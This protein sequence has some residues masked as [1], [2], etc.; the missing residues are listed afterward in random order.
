MA[1]R[2]ARLLLWGLWGA[3]LGGA[4]ALGYLVYAYTR[5]LPD[6]SAFERLRLSAPP[7][8]YARGGPTLALLA[9][10]E[11]GRAIHRSLVRLS[12]VSPAALAAIVFSE[13]RRFYSHYGV[14]PVRLL[15]ALYAVLTGDLQGGSTITTQV[16]KNT[17][18]K[19]LAQAR[20]LERKVKE[21]VLALELERRYTKA[22]IL[23]MYLNVVPWGGN[24]VGIR[25]AA[26]AYFGKDPAALTLAEGLY[27]ASL[28][29]AP[30]ARYQDLEGVRRRMRRV[31]DEMVREGWITEA[32]AEQAWKEPLKPRGWE[33]RYDEEGNLLEA[34]LVDPEA[35]ILRSVDYRLAPH[36]VLEVRRFL[37]ERFGK[38]K[39]YGEGGL[40]VY[41]TLDPRMQ[42]AAEKAARA[43][44]L[45]EGA[46][47]AI[48][49]LDPET[50]EV[51]AMVGGVRRENDEYNRATRA[52]RNPGSAVKP[53]V[54][55]AA[56]EAGWTQV[57]LVPDRPME[58]KDPSQP[59]GVWRPKNFSGTFLNREITVRYALDLSLNL[60]AVYTAQAVG[61][62]RVAAKLA[63]AG[64]AV[65]YA[66]PAIAIGGASITPVDLAAA[67]A[68]FVNGGYRVAP[69][70]VLRMEDQEGRVL[71][72]AA[73]HRTR[74]FSP[75]VAYQGWDLLKGYV[76][77][78]GEKGLAKGARIPGRVVGGKTGTTN[79]ARDL[80]FAGVT[81]G[82]S[83]VVWVGRDDNRPLRMGGR[84]PSSSVVNPPIWRN[85][86]AEALRGLCPCGWTWRPA[87][88]A[89][90]GWW[91]TC[92]RARCPRGGPR[93]KAPPC[94]FP[95][96]SSRPRGAGFRRSC[97]ERVRIV[98]VEPQEPM[99]LGAVARAMRNFGLSRLYVVNP[100][101]RVGPPWAKEAYWLAVHA[102]E[103]LEKAQVAGS[104]LEA[105]RGAQLVVATTGRP[106]EVYPAP[107]APAWEVADRVA[108]FPGEVALV[109]GRET[110]GLTNEELELAHLI[111]YIPT[112]PEQPSLNLAQAVVV[113]AYELFK[114][115]G[116]G[117]GL[118][119]GGEPAPVEALEAF[120][121]DLGRYILEIGFTD[122]RRFP[123]AMRRLR[124]IF[125]KAGLTLGEVQMLRGLLHQ[126]RF[127][128]RRKD[129]GA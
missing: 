27:L 41:T 39:V 15:G 108:A 117:V 67:Y 9:S 129:D 106:R 127:A 18:L 125:H 54:Y 22:E 124:R 2:L 72:Q 101:P 5:D 50:G 126:S 95:S 120:F 80:W 46:D 38:E 100:P 26:E 17:L 88:R 59:G 116:K 63:Q 6:L 92:P 114:R 44:R 78:L 20:T 40:R 87:C 13:D 94:P 68:A 93:R 16:I 105:L 70:L 86:V 49:G 37:E 112:A 8:L 32:L 7:S 24:A 104:L 83:A 48:V 103:V 107:V 128:Q 76:Y 28:I 121:Q 45:P 43:A 30:N 91:S 89:R 51:L 118:R 85:F 119:E 25:A 11:D 110:F 60:P 52:L 113:F 74:L 3:V 55:A 4:G 10:V 97:V 75:E 84:E 42:E 29:P 61:L 73:P 115:Q 77:D 58:F 23:E 111:G 79:E 64:F 34:R 57:T 96:P 36:F 122:E 33:V 53:F 12:E 47:L 31:L 19:E 71:Y 35:R 21:W 109:F 82:L 65:R 81:R 99:N 69:L 62:D 98:L 1:V 14:D 102:E 66:V 90:R 56:L 123:Y